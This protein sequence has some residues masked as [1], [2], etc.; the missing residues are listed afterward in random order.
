MG[1][2]GLGIGDWGLGIGDWGLGARGKRSDVGRP[3]R[4]DVGR[5]FQG[6]RGEA[7]SLALHVCRR[8]AFRLSKEAD[9]V[10][11]SVRRTRC[12]SMRHSIAASC[13]AAQELAVFRRDRHV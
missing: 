10:R 1:D 5:P 7:E 8:L 9:A 12:K 13:L 11:M 4:S 6:R 3:K 2:W